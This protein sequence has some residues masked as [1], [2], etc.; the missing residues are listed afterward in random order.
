M[1]INIIGDLPKRIGAR[2]AGNA[3][4]DNGWK[5]SDTYEYVWEDDDEEEVNLDSLD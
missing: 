2:V 1:C 3:G 5:D 4:G